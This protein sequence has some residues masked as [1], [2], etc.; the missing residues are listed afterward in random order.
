MKRN[1]MCSFLLSGVS[2]AEFGLSIPSPF[3]SLEISNSEI[4]SF[5]NWSLNVV[6][7]G[8]DAKKSNV[9]A[10]EALL[11]TAAQN[12][13]MYNNSSGIPVSFMFGWLDENGNISEYLSYQGTTLQ[14]E[15]S[16]SGPYMK[17]KVDGYASLALK[18]SMPVL[19][20]PALS[21]YVKP[22]AVVEGFA[23][24]VKA[25]SYYDLDIDHS[26][27]P[28]YINHGAMS[29]S[30][31]SYVR[32]TRT[33][34]DNYDEF[35]GL[36]PLSKS[37][38]SSRDAAGLK[39]GYKKLSTIL[40]NAVVTPVADFLDKSLTDPT[41]Q[42]SAFSFWIDEPTMTRRGVIHYKD[43]SSIVSAH[44]ED[45]LQYGTAQSNILSINGSYNGIAYNMSDMNFSTIGFVVDG[46]GNSIADTSKVVNSWSSS[47]PEVYQ[48]ADIINDI[49]ALAT[50]FSGNFTVTIPGSLKTYGICDPVSLLVMHGNTLSPV[51]GIYSIVSVTHTIS[52]T[53]IT[54]LKL[55]RLA[56]SSAS[57]VA[58]SAGIFVPGSKSV[59]TSSTYKHTSNIISTD[60]VD[61]G[62]LYPTFEH[63]VI[64]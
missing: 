52:S 43:K 18:S 30:F 5:T 61:F 31:T 20:V 15:A 36:L 2:L 38:N 6:I 41:P 9:A 58:S 49:N 3:C 12:A 7:G 24:A 35:P 33:G 51:S 56:I 22:S 60:K 46:S 45:V 55:Q 16:V 54:T 13:D 63:I 19:N 1:P 34:E 37:Y 44:N 21:G 26:D 4:T 27:A 47:L 14:F 25:D 53:F 42:C 50:Q 59:S 40:N 8:D 23:K 11:Y 57:Q 64:K 10:F 48:T 32:G 39:K 29:T 17:Y 28:T 62:T